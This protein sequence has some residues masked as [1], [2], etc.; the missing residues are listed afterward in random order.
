VGFPFEM[1]F[2]GDLEEY[3]EQAWRIGL[4]EGH[5]DRGGDMQAQFH[6]P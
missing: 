5:A 6:W 4:L 1:L 3:I 2:A